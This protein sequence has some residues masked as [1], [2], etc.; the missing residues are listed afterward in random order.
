MKKP[1]KLNHDAQTFTESL[2]ITAERKSELDEAIIN[3]MEPRDIVRSQIIERCYKEADNL[4]ELIYLLDHMVTYL[5]EC[6]M[7]LKLSDN[8]GAVNNAIKAF[9]GK[10][11]MFTI[12]I[13]VKLLLMDLTK[14]VNYDIQTL[15]Q[16]PHGTARKG[17]D[18]KAD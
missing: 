7:L 5:S 8:M 1:F 15:K 12:K 3:M 2:A 14:Y 17:V 18:K 4:A 9:D 16:E 13:V 11:D 6:G 10:L